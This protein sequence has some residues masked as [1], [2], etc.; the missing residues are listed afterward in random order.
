MQPARADPS[1]QP[2]LP[3]WLAHSLAAVAYPAAHRPAISTHTAA[4]RPAADRVDGGRSFC[5]AA[6]AAAGVASAAAAGP[7]TSAGRP[8]EGCAGSSVGQ[9]ES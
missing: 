5:T 1:G 6:A 2:E 8:S 7:F 9:F 3:V 4:A